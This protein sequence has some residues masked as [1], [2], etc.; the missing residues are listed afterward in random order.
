MVYDEVT[1]KFNDK[2]PDLRWEG[3]EP[4]LVVL[5]WHLQDLATE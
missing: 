5:E 4:T 1:D 3:L 2:I